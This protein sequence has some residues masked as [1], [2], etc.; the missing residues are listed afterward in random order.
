MRNVGTVVHLAGIVG[1]PAC[2]LDEGLTIDVNLTS[3]RS[4]AD[5]AKYSQVPRFVFASTCSVYGACDEILDERS[6]AKPVSLYG[7]TKLA[8]EKVLRDMADDTFSPTVLRFATIYGLSGRTRFDL[9]VNL[10]AAKAKID[11][12]ITI[13]NGAQWRPFVHVMDAASAI[14][15]AVDAP[16]D[17][18]HNEIFNVGSNEQNHT[19]LEVGEMIHQQVIGAELIVDDSGSDARNYRVDFTKIQEHLGF[20]PQWTLLKGI[21]QVLHAI[22]SGK[23]GDYRDPKYSNYAFLNLQGTTE[24]ARDHWALEMIRNIEEGV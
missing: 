5:M 11:S 14:K 19:I 4:I 3:T 17:V 23:V 10:L 13:F 22:A 16:S 18:V 6:M 20:T 2:N 8:S 15:L 9:V 1:D 12:K 21:E 24:L 7:N